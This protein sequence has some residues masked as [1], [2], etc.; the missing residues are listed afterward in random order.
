MILIDGIKTMFFAVFISILPLFL[1]IAQKNRLEKQSD[2]FVYYN[3][4][5]HLD[6]DEENF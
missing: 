2:V 4:R 6:R 3:V 1:N 5:S